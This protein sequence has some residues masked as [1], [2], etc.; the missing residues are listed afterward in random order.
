M[1]SKM[2]AEEQISKVYQ[3]SQKR[4]NLFKSTLILLCTV[5]SLGFFGFQ[6]NRIV[7]N[8]NANSERMVNYLRCVILLPAA[9]F[10]GTTE[11]RAVA[12]DNCS[13]QTK[14]PMRVK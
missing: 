3:R 14:I 12:V 8:T 6:A 11:Q 13:L 2:N 7:T 9:S 10:Q 4:Y 1:N 5:G